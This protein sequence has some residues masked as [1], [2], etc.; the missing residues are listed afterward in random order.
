ML[1]VTEDSKII[2]AFNRYYNFSYIFY[3]NQAINYRYDRQKQ[4]KFVLLL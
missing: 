4:M 3:I 2:S 1:P